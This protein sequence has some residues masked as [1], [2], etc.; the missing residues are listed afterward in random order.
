ME[1]IC[2]LMQGSSHAKYK[3]KGDDLAKE[4][5]IKAIL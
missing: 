2:N 3:E 4:R 5:G 1:S